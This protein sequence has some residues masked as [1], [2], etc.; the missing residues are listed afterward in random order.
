MRVLDKKSLTDNVRTI[1][2]VSTLNKTLKALPLARASDFFN[3]LRRK[4]GDWSKIKI[5][6]LDIMGNHLENEDEKRNNILS[7]ME[8]KY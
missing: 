6:I 4:W 1:A 5:R 2:D 8:T 3:K 7:T